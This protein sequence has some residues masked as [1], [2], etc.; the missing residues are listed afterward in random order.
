MLQLGVI[1][2]TRC[3]VPFALE[4]PDLGLDFSLIQANDLV[5]LVQIQTERLAKRH[6]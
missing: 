3:L 1:V 5:M 6:K 4:F 2:N